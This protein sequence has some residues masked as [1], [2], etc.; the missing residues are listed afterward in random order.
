MCVF[1]QNNAGEQLTCW[2]V[3]VCSAVQSCAILGIY[4]ATCIHSCTHTHTH[5]HTLSLVEHT[6]GHE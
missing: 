5:S 6:N 1:V 3:C 4:T 2:F